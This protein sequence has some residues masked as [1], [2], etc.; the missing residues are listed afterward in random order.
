MAVDEGQECVERLVDPVKGEESAVRQLEGEADDIDSFV[1][2]MNGMN[3]VGDVQS[4]G[5]IFADALARTNLSVETLAEGVV[6]TSRLLT[7]ESS[8]FFPH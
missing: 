6:D 3:A 4:E 7:C 8:F 2:I 5:C 1:D